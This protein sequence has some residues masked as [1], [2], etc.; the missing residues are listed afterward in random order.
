MRLGRAGSGWP[1]NMHRIRSNSERNQQIGIPA[2]WST[3]RWNLIFNGECPVVVLGLWQGGGIIGE[4]SAFNKPDS[5]Y[6]SIRQ[7]WNR[8]L[9]V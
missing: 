3:A 1:E 9:F 6:T 7:L 2:Q 4:S 8:C 5:A